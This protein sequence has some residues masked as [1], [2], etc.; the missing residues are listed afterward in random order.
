MYSKAW[1]IACIAT[2]LPIALAQPEQEVISFLDETD[3]VLTVYPYLFP[4]GARETNIYF[5]YAEPGLD[6]SNQPR[7]SEKLHEFASPTDV[8]AVGIYHGRSDATCELYNEHDDRSEVF[9]PTQE[10][11]ELIRPFRGAL[12]ITC[13]LPRLDG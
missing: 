1:L 8:S 10:A 12:G 4:I 7:E 2:A 6:D 9:G 3:I 5:N 11:Q 13:H